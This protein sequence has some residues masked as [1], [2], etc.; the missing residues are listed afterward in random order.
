MSPI[1]SKYNLVDISIE[2]LVSVQNER[3]NNCSARN[4]FGR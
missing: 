3:G 1:I 4:T 2:M